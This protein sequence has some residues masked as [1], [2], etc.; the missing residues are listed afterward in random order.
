MRDQV[1]TPYGGAVPDTPDPISEAHRQWSARWPEHADRMAA[2]TSVMRAQQ[3]L[4]SRIEAVLKP[5]GLTF[6]AYEALRLLAFTRTGTMPMGKMGTRLMVHPA[7]VTNVIGRLERRGLVGR[8]PS[9]DDRRVVL[10]TITP[11]GRDLAEEATAALNDAA[12]GIAA[13]PAERAAEITAALR[14]VRVSVGELSD[15]Q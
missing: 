9:P 14:A 1:K 3:L 10:A 4:L 5:H 13:L 15:D 2:V 6:A 8:A 11:A 7:S 12:F